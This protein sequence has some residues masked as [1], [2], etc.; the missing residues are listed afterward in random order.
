MSAV[1]EVMA[2]LAAVTTTGATS[3]TMVGSGNCATSGCAKIASASDCTAAATTQGTSLGSGVVTVAGSAL[4][5]Y[6]TALPNGCFTLTGAAAALGTVFYND[7]GSDSTP[8]TTGASGVMGQCF[9]SCGGGGRRA[10][11]T[12]ISM[13]RSGTAITFTATVPNNLLASAQTGYS[14]VTSDATVLLTKMA[15]A[16]TV[17]VASGEISSA[18]PVPAPSAISAAVPTPAPTPTPTNAPVAAASTTTTTTNEKKDLSDGA[19]AG[20]AVAIVVVVIIGVA[21][22]VFTPKPVVEDTD[23]VPMDLEISKEYGGGGCGP[24]GGCVPDGRLC[25]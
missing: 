23:K 24:D 20:I 14:A 4:A 17:M 19:I 13:R 3:I 21:L 8:C 16:N 7:G 25:C 6:A 10:G 5:G 11:L 9:C 18:V 1:L 2:F 12:Q 15:D 22:I